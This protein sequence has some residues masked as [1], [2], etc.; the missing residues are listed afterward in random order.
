[1][2]PPPGTNIILLQLLGECMMMLASTRELHQG[3]LCP[4]LLLLLLEEAPA[5]GVRG[6]GAGALHLPP[7]GQ[8]ELAPI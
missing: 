2:I 1:M 6:H 4:G 3:R 8:L 5:L 7:Q